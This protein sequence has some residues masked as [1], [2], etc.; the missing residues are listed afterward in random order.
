MKPYGAK[1][2]YRPGCVCCNTADY[3][4]YRIGRCPSEEVKKA[5]RA[6]KKRAR[7]EGN[8]EIKEYTP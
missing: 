5:K 8:K 4:H 3:H 2:S 7:R 6:A 1:M